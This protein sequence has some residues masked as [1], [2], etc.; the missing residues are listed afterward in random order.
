MEIAIF[1]QGDFKSVIKYAE[2]FK[3]EPLDILVA[4]AGVALEAYTQTEDGWEMT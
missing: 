1:D 3:D 2:S 4:N